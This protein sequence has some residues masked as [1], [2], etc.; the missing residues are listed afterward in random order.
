[1][2]CVAIL[3][4]FTVALCGCASLESPDA[5]ERA[6][7]LARVHDPLRLKELALRS[8][9]EDVRGGALARIDDSGV[10]ADIALD[11]ASPHETRMTAVNRI[12]G[13]PGRQEPCLRV[14]LAS[15]D[16]VVALTALQALEPDQRASAD[17]RARMLHWWMDRLQPPHVH[18]VIYICMGGLVGKSSDDEVRLASL[19]ADSR[20]GQRVFE[21]VRKGHDIEN[22]G[23]LM[24]LA[25][26]KYAV[27]PAVRT[28]AVGGLGDGELDALVR[29]NVPEEVRDA[30]LAKMKGPQLLADI[31]LDRQCPRFLRERAFRRA[32][33]CSD[34]QHAVLHVY[35]T[36]IEFWLAKAALEAL[37]E[38]SH[39]DSAVRIRTLKWF[40]DESLESNERAAVFMALSGADLSATDDQARLARLISDASSWRLVFDKA[41]REQTLVGRRELLGFADGSIK[42]DESVALWSVER[43]A[44][45]DL[46]AVAG[47]TPMKRVAFK[48]VACIRADA[49]LEVVALGTYD[50]VLRIWAVEHLRRGSEPALR[51]IALS[52]E[53]KFRQLALKRLKELG[54]LSDDIRAEVGHVVERERAQ[55]E[56]KAERVRALRQS[57][58]AGATRRLE[59]AKTD[60]SI[61]RY[62]KRVAESSG[63]AGDPLSFNGK[64]DSITSRNWHPKVVVSV[65]GANRSLSVVCQMPSPLGEALKVGDEVLVSGRFKS[66]NGREVHLTEAR[67]EPMEDGGRK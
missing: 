48:A 12:V 5:G 67:F 22:R 11:V 54:L 6:V 51:K 55:D 57:A 25:A 10:L 3:A 14:F 27:S 62:R 21:I 8:N 2:R 61:V 52:E 58:L 60:Q 66:G 50:P 35:L 19:L 45:E 56:Q 49:A 33:S 18:A 1:M 40:R 32:C 34:G 47:K 46:L 28:W 38:T 26:G 59:L 30:A 42:A 15:D 36:A 31:A 44:D 29:K 7:A 23:V 16:L 43:L 37:P 4:L 53:R 24:D 13:R 39:V 63:L 17:V 64:V 65:K 9:W 41:V 20:Y